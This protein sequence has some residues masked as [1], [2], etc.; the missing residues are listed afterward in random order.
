ML[1]A[2]KKFLRTFDAAA[3]Q[4]GERIQTRDFLVVAIAR[5]RTWSGAMAMASACAHSSRDP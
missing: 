4:T 5:L 1:R 2:G 3:I